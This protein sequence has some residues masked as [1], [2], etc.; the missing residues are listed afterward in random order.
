MKLGNTKLIHYGIQD[1]DSD[2]RIHVGV[3]DKAVYVFEPRK[4]IDA[5]NK[6]N[7]HQASTNQGKIKTAIGYL[8]PPKNIEGCRRYPIPESLFQKTNFKATDN[9]SVKGRKAER[10]VKEMIVLGHINISLFSE[11]MEEEE[12]Q[13]VGSDLELIFAK[14]FQIKCD[15]KA[16]RPN[17]YIQTDECNPFKFT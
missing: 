14:S 16:G 8:V 2:L 3:M 12:E 7:Y 9:P 10:L 5:I 11:F 4:A 13:I 15:W 1:D 17:L 6:G